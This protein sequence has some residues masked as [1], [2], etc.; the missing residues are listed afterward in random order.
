M[1]FIF[2]LSGLI[3]YFLGAMVFTRPQ[4]ALNETLA[5]LIIVNGTLFIIGAGIIDAIHNNL[6]DKKESMPEAPKEKERIEP[7]FS[8]DQ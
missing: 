3:A 1:R 7:T 5:L 8:G 6:A 2:F 4:G